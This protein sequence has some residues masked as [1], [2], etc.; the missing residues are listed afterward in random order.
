MRNLFDLS[1]KR[2]LITGSARGIGYLL[3]E[4][5]AEY[6]AEI[7]INDRTQQK[8]DAAAQALRE[9]GYR[10]TGVAFDVTRSVE[11]E[12]AIAR[13]E[14]Q[15]GA[16]DILINNA[17]IQRRYPFTEFPEEEWDQVIEVVKAN[18][19]VEVE[20]I[21]PISSRLVVNQASLKLKREL[22]QPVLEAFAGAVKK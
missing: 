12:Q 11:V 7:I 1:G 17:G 10:A 6:G 2:A 14:A 4:G 15:I 16:I 21:M 22:I 20:D 9:Q 18:N 8:A 5:L 13:I 3:A 19:L